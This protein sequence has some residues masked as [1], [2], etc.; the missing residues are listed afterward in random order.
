MRNEEQEEKIKDISHNPYSKTKWKKK[1][2]KKFEKKKNQKKTMSNLG[3][4]PC[5][6]YPKWGGYVQL[7][8]HRHPWIKEELFNLQIQK[9]IQIFFNFPSARD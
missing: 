6:I 8:C 5:P 9:K 4:W 7:P 3:D 1:S 2:K